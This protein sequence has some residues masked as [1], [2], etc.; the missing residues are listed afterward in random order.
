MNT[1]EKM[2]LITRNC[3]EVLTEEDLKVLI[4]SGKEIRHYIGL[5]IS[6]MVHFGTGLM[7]MG[8]IADF[9][10]AGVTCRVFLADFHTFLNNK[11]GGK[12]EDIRWASEHY[13]KEALIASMKCFGCKPTTH[14][15]K[16][17]LD[18]AKESATKPKHQ[19][20]FAP[21]A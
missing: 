14:Q 21:K 12:W 8:K 15:S 7:V 2:K 9:L 13:F 4:E 16:K 6:G 5:E 3:Q 11:L 17:Q 10:K 18:P 19:H 20:I 1:E